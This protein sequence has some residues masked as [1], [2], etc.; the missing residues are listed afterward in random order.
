[1]KFILIIHEHEKIFHL[2]VFKCFNMFKFLLYVFY[3]FRNLPRYLH[4]SNEV[5]SLIS[6][7]DWHL[8]TWRL[9]II[10]C[11]FCN[12]FLCW[13][14][15]SDV[16]LPGGVFS[17]LCTESYHLQIRMLWFFFSCLHFFYFSTCIIALAK[18]SN[19]IWTKM[20][21]AGILVSILV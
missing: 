12:L 14:H 10:V 7:Y 3:F 16:G 15:L 2:L 8:Y 18:A 20:M 21:K 1:M 17:L 11:L 4:F 9:V 6:C 19:T 13:R 5:S